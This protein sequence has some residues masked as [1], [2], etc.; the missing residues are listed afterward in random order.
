M[1]HFSKISAHGNEFNLI[2]SGALAFK[3]HNKIL[4]DDAFQQGAPIKWNALLGS[5]AERQ[6][7]VQQKKIFFVVISDLDK[8]K[9]E[10]LCRMISQERASGGYAVCE[11]IPMFH[12]EPFYKSLKLLRQNFDEVIELNKILHVNSSAHISA[13]QQ[14]CIVSDYSVSMARIMFNTSVGSL[15]SSRQVQETHEPVPVALYA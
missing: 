9:V 8:L 14:Q 7:A 15:K 12:T 6:A 4:K 2:A 13:E 3:I 10:S 5:T 11:V 1:L